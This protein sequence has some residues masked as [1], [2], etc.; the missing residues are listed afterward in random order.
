MKKKKKNNQSTSYNIPIKFIFVGM[1]LISCSGWSIM[2]YSLDENQESKPKV[3]S[4]ITDNEGIEH[5]YNGNINSGENWCYNHNQYET[6]EI[7]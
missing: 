6:V 5:F 7:K 3:L 1:L 2:G 4:T